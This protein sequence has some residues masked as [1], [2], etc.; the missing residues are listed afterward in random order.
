MKKILLALLLLIPIPVEAT[1]YYVATTGNDAAAGTIGAPWQH[2]AY[3]VSS[4]SAAVAGDTIYVR[5]GTY[6]EYVV[7][8][9]NPASTITLS[10][11]PT[12]D[13][14]AG[15]TGTVCAASHAILTGGGALG[16]IVF[17][18]N[19]CNWTISGFEIKD[20]TGGAGVYY[21]GDTC[22]GTQRILRN[23]IHNTDSGD[24]ASSI[25]LQR[26]GGAFIIQD[27]ILYDSDG[28][29]PG[30]NTGIV[31]FGEITTSSKATSVTIQNNEIYNEGVAIKFKHPY[32]SGQTVSVLVEKNLLHDLNGKGCTNDATGTY[33]TN[34]TVIFRYNI[35]YNGNEGWV[36]GDDFNSQGSQLYNNTV[37]N[38]NSGAQIC[39][40]D[41][42]TEVPQSNSFDWHDNIFVPVAISGQNGYGIWTENTT[43]PFSP[44]S[45]YNCF[46]NISPTTTIA[47]YGGFGG[48]SSNTLA[49][50]QAH[51]AAY[52]ANSTRTDPLFVNTTTHDFHLQSGSG[53]KNLRADGF[54]AGAYRTGS[55]VIGTTPSGA[56]PASGAGTPNLVR[57][58]RK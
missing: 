9:K 23:I 14:A 17:L 35:C 39:L 51:S 32:N 20:S 5:A 42:C 8:G 22:T 6:N 58:K 52:D 7:M 16:N 27:N 25:F 13:C 3:A 18:G 41:N 34:K 15:S 11:Y 43:N 37:Y 12:E 55:E 45:N 44:S 46:W 31:I 53:C 30:N 50:W 2:V 40:A 38:T 1:N 4:S 29:T 54:D 47:Q 49:Q 21:E 19:F 48:G 57:I 33:S 10:A 24:N 36:F 56:P 26:V 28:T